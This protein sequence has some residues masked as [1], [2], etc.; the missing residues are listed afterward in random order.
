MKS[1]QKSDQLKGSKKKSESSFGRSPSRGSFG[2]NPSR[3]NFGKNPNRGDFGKNP[4][5][6][7][8]KKSPAK[9]TKDRKSSAKSISRSDLLKRAQVLF[10][11]FIR[12][13]DK[14]L[15]CISCGDT[16]GVMEAG[17][18]MSVGSLANLR[19]D[20]NNCHKQCKICNSFKAG[21]IAE[22]RPRLIDKIGEEEVERLETSRY[23]KKF[24][25][26]ELLEITRT[27]MDQEKEDLKDIENKINQILKEI[28]D[29]GIEDVLDKGLIVTHKTDKDQSGVGGVEAIVHLDPEIRVDTLSKEVFYIG[30]D[31]IRKGY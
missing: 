14:D 19:F 3:G 16:N 5:M 10:N 27:Y 21:N 23:T 20:E 30:T 2:K 8:S 6:L 17:H 28:E 18:Y 9:K 25:N 11:R 1:Y 26:K 12:N 7:G 22:Y 15:P 4:S 29:R 31:I 24:T 13:R